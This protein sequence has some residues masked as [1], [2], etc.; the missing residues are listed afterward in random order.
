MEPLTIAGLRENY[1]L[2]RA[3]P[4]AVA[5]TCLA[6]AADEAARGV[7]ITL[8]PERALREARA[9]DA[10][11]RAGR[12]LSMLDGIPVSWKDMFDVAG[13]VTTAGSRALDGVPASRDALAVATLS[14]LGAICIGKTNLSELAFSGL[15]L[16]P[17]HG[18]PRNPRGPL[19]EHYV[20]GGS[21]SGAAASVALGLCAVAIGTDTSGSVRVP[22]AFTGLYG[23][24]PGR[25]AWSLDGVRGLAPSLDAL[26][27]IANTPEDA[28]EVHAALAT[29]QAVPA[30]AW[31]VSRIVAEERLFAASDE[32]VREHGL[33]ALCAFEQQGVVVECC[34]VPELAAVRELFERHGTLV[35][36]EAVRRHRALLDAQGERID[37]LVR[38]RLDAARTI[39]NAQYEALKSAQAELTRALRCRWPST[40]FAF[41]TSPIT[42]PAAAALQ[43]P[44][45]YDSANSRAL[46]HT[47]LASYLDLAGMALPTGADSEGLPTSLLLSTSAGNE[48]ALLALCRRAARVSGG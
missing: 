22:A 19:H 3:S 1:R 31:R 46:S 21:S 18:T 39:T 17:W 44:E 41:P 9:S 16:N 32:A 12:P 7:F 23:W 2:A 5:R 40:V 27:V 20:C 10:R 25:M 15:G 33:R 36:A 34:S 45:V 14:R 13:T 4:G 28:A 38:R 43:K 42:A 6:R 48:N 30:R 8:T 26:G 11:W 29:A 47:M 37:P 35:A 24:K